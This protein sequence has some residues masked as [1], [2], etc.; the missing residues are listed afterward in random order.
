MTRTPKTRTAP[1]GELFD[2]ILAAEDRDH[3]PG[4]HP[5]ISYSDQDESAYL[6]AIEA[7]ALRAVTLTRRGVYH[8]EWA[9][10]D[11]ERVPAREADETTLAAAFARRWHRAQPIVLPG[12]GAEFLAEFADEIDGADDVHALVSEPGGLKRWIEAFSEDLEPSFRAIQRRTPL[13][14]RERDVER[15]RF[16][17][18]APN[19]RGRPIDDLWIKSSWLSTHDDDS[20]LRVRFSFGREED[21]DA[22]RDILRHRLVADLAERML[23]E[24]A[25]I[26][27]NPLLVPL[28]EHLCGERVLFTQHI[29]YWNSPNGG[30][31]FHHDAFAEDQHDGG[32]WRQFGVAY[33][34][35]SGTTAWLALSI[36][37]LSTRVREFVDALEDG[38]LSWVRAQLFESGASHVLGW[39]RLREIVDDENAL[40]YEL[41]L[42]GCGS[43]RSTRQSRAGV[44][45]VPG[46]R[47]SRVDSVPRRR[48][49]AAQSRRARDVHALGVLRERRNGL[50]PFARDPPRPRI[51]RRR[52]RA[53]GFAPT[54]ASLD[55]RPCPIPP[56]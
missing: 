24:S 30:A 39:R 11:P 1:A 38:E 55:S 26:S 41:G 16:E 56:V 22:S 45:V 29:A 31:S 42:P 14:D 6:A 52:A 47:G 17:S 33:M 12:I 4:A 5:V 3:C 40:V 15:V 54:Q 23:P 53:R 28:V 8:G 48:D 25:A 21:D 50:Q 7:R 20:S 19:G 10:L 13:F 43:A 9:E 44:H 51:A 18:F 37:D 32:A 35:L 34:Q 27:A 36:Q 46:R 49:F 2:S